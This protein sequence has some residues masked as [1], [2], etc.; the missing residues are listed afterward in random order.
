MPSPRTAAVALWLVWTALV[1]GVA[2]PSRAEP[3][4]VPPGQD[5]GGAAVAIMTPPVDLSDDTVR[6]RL[7]RDGEG[8]AIGWDFSVQKEPEQGNASNSQERKLHTVENVLATFANLPG[9]R[10]VPVIVNPDAPLTWGEAAAFIARTPARIVVVPFTTGNESDW[11]A[12][13]AAADHFQHLVFIVPANKVTTAAS[14]SL[15]YPAALNLRNVVSVATSS[16]V[17]ADIA[18]HQDESGSMAE[19][20]ATTVARLTECGVPGAENTGAVFDKNEVLSLFAQ[21]GT[22]P[23]PGGDTA[24]K[25]QGSPCPATPN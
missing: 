4:D 9:H 25:T 8:V 22:Q 19:M 18:L 15:A 5:P 10:L 6:Q 2:V 1:V 16:S 3:L 24:G 21:T 11:A 12:F 20:L 14:N 7:A 23:G 13:R 17:P